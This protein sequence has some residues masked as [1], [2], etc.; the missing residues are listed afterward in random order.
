M[1]YTHSVEFRQLL[2]TRNPAGISAMDVA[3]ADVT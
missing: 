2:I 1:A 3:S